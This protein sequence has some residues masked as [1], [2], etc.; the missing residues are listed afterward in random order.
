VGVAHS[1]AFDDWLQETMT[2]KNITNEI[3]RGSLAQWYQAPSARE[4]QPEGGDEHMTPLCVVLGAG[5]CGPARSVGVRM[6]SAA[7][8]FASSQFEY[9]SL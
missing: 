9:A 2:S 3:R 8:D 1:V 5:G 7:N 6:D 4:C